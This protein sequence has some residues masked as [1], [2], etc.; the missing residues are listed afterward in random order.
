MTAIGGLL[1]FMALTSALVKRLPISTSII[2]LMVGVAVG[3]VGFG[4]LGLDIV[5]QREWLELVTEI[6]VIVSLFVGGLKLRVPLHHPSWTSAFRLAGPVMLLSI[7]AAAVASHLLLG[8]PVFAAMLLG[9]ILAPTD[10]VL[11]SAVAVNDASDEDRVRFAL[12]GE[13]GL[14]DGAAFPFVVFALEGMRAG[15]ELGGWVGPWF[16]SRVL[17]AVPAGL[18]IGYFMGHWIG[19][20]AIRVRSKQRDTGAPSDFLALALIAL[21]YVVAERLHAW[22]FLAVFAAGVGLR[23][24]ELRIVEETPHPEVQGRVKRWF[25]RG[26][27]VE[28]AH[29]PAETLVSANVSEESMKQPAVAAGVMI[30]EMLSFGDTA[31]RL[32]EV[33]LVVVVGI[34]LVQSWSWDAAILSL[35]LFFVIRPS[36]ALLMLTGTRTTLGQ[37]GLMGWFGIRGIG[38]LYYLAYALNHGVSPSSADALVASVVTAV[39]CSIVVHGVTVTPVLDLY[40]KSLR[41]RGGR[42]DRGEKS[43]GNEAPDAASPAANPAVG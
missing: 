15:G 38:S 40:E 30:S 16:L 39:A 27:P 35:V 33:M 12:S 31:E 18:V 10:P 25:A 21:T 19:R 3:P 23:R 4:L 2:Y 42:N 7:A 26:H 36:S 8:L 9:A 11:A 37:R 13:A 20:L 29:P 22:G 43:T 6:A 1:L 41:R 14:N 32:L 17:W 28:K 24:A 5:S 34:T